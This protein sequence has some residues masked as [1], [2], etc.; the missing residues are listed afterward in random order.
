[1]MNK[2]PETQKPKRPK[3]QPRLCMIA[4]G[5]SRLA[6]AFAAVVIAAARRGGGAPWP[7][8]F[9][10]GRPLFVWTE[11]AFARVLFYGGGN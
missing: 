1:M 4:A 8:L 6:I 7:V 2:K 10:G 5:T 3:Q 9:R 11:T